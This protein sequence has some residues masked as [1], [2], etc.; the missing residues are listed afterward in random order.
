M[1]R[2]QAVKSQRNAVN[3]DMEEASGGFYN[4]LR[5]KGTQSQGLPDT[6]KC[7]QLKSLQ[8]ETL[9]FESRA[10]RKDPGVRTTS[11]GLFFLLICWV[12]NQK[13][14]PRCEYSYFHT[15]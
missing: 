11:R 10:G 8:L 15:P 3:T 5:P 9:Q 7:M 14:N 6:H 13:N 2:K 1:K 4:P 12:K